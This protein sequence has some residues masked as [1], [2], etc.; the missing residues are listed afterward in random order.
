[1]RILMTL[2]VLSG[3]GGNPLDGD[4]DPVTDAEDVPTWAEQSEETTCTN[5]LGAPETCHV[6]CADFTSL[7]RDAD[8]SRCVEFFGF[9]PYPG[10]SV[11]V[12]ACDMNDPNN[13]GFVTQWRG[14]TGCCV[15]RDAEG[16]RP[17]RAV[18]MGCVVE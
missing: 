1:M 16:T 11:N 5:W 13:T 6:P 3:C 8:V 4:N 17:E 9:D 10:T 12:L 14:V 15:L 7:V 2:V 18:F